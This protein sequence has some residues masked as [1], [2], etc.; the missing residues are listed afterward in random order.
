LLGALDDQRRI[1]RT[2]LVGRFGVDSRVREGEDAQVAVRPG[3]LRFF[4][5]ESGRRIGAGAPTEAA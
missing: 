2:A 3:A 4:D 5:P 1:R